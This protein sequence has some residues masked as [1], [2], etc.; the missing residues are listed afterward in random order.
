MAKAV[1][2]P[3][4]SPISGADPVWSLIDPCTS[5]RGGP[6]PSTQTA[7]VPPSLVSTSHRSVMLQIL[8]LSHA[9]RQV[10]PRSLLCG[11]EGGLELRHAAEGSESSTYPPEVFRRC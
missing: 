4:S 11:R 3:R 1:A 2:S 9:A 6:C 8:A 7:I 10:Q 5:T